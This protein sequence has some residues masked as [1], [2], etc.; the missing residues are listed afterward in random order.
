MDNFDNISNIK[1]LYSLLIIVLI[2]FN[3]LNVKNVHATEND[4]RVTNIEVIQQIGFNVE[5]K[6]MFEKTGLFISIDN[7]ISDYNIE[8]NYDV[9]NVKIEEVIDIANLG[10]FE[11]TDDNVNGKLIISD[12][13][14][15]V[16]G[17]D[18]GLCFVP[19]SLIGKAGINAE[20][21]VSFNLEQVKIVSFCRGKIINDGDEVGL[22][23]GIVGLQ[24]LAGIKDNSE[25]NVVNMASIFP[26]EIINY[27][28]PSVKNVI[29]LMQYLV[30]LRDEYFQIK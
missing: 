19:I 3:I 24:Y 1:K 9:S 22:S 20:V 7:E 26:Y 29:V 14:N 25:I 10:S 28:K 8:I 12:N 21:K 23:D 16:N 15:N 27:F 5:T 13:G 17:N 6:V 11:F 30:G 4:F 2:L 18:N